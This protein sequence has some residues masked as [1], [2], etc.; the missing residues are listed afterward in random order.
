MGNRPPIYSGAYG[1]S[2]MV[3][4]QYIV[5]VT[6]KEKTMNDI[7]KGISSEKSHFSPGSAYNYES[8]IYDST[9]VRCRIAIEWQ[10]NGSRT[11]L[12]RSRIVTNA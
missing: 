9:F 1:Q 2:P 5:T 10:S 11:L 6:L 7:I 4:K 8:T 3:Y 12:N